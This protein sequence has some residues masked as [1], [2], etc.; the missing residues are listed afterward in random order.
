MLT[1][2]EIYDEQADQ[3][4]NSL[5]AITERR[6]VVKEIEQRFES[7]QLVDQAIRD[8]EGPVYF[9]LNLA[10]SRFGAL[11][12]NASVDSIKQL[13]P[14]LKVFRDNGWRI[15]SGPDRELVKK[16]AN[17]DWKLYPADVTL[18]RDKNGKR[19]KPEFYISL[20]VSARKCERVKV[21][22]KVV[23]IYEVVCS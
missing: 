20:S 13:T 23:D 21:G 10:L 7:L 6:A 18:A 11:Y 3:D 2:Q 16:G 4:R 9:W 14:L 5:D 22:Q 12:C 1:L 17:R 8:L 19:A 15:Y